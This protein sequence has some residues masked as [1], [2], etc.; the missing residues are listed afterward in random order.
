MNIR[1]SAKRARSAWRIR[2]LFQLYWLHLMWRRVEW[3]PSARRKEYV[4][5]V[6]QI[7]KQ[8]GRKA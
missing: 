5:R 1:H 4:D 8:K 6:D 2:I 3:D 7:V